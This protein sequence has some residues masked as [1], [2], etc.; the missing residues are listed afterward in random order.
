MFLNEVIKNFKFYKDGFFGYGEKGDFE[1]FSFFHFLPIII[2][3]TAIILTYIFRKKIAS[4]KYEK[5]VRFAIGCAILL[6]E[7]SYYWRLL[8]VGLEDSESD[9]FLTQLP[10][11]ICEWTA[12]LAALMLFTENKTCFDINVFICLT[13]GLFPLITPAVITNAGPAYFRYYQFFGLHL[14]PIYAVFYMI[15]VRNFKYD[16]KMVYKSVI[17]LMILIIISIILN[18]NIEGANYLYLSNDTEGGSIANIF[19]KNMYLKLLIYLGIVIFMFAIEYL[20][21]RLSYYFADK[22][23]NNK[24]S[25]NIEN[26]K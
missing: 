26:K 3:I 10:F 11:Q 14:L 23:R 12:I 22:I 24:A 16:L 2:L 5:Q 13:L 25:K 1:Y 15:F 7:V 19:P 17:F 9:T 20:I 6:F 4:Y 18:E 8:Y 21:F